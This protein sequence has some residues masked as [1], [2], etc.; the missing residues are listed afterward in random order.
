MVFVV[1]KFSDII[2]KIIPFFEKNPLLGIK[3]L[4]YQDLSKIAFIKR[5]K[6]YL[7]EEE[8]DEIS[9][10]KYGMNRGRK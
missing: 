1:Y 4:D 9:K 3:K 7:T 10:I 5:E 2:E 8:I 6:P